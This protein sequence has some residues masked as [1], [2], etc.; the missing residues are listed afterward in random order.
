MAVAVPVAE[1]FGLPAFSQM[2]SVVR[3]Y[4]SWA[5]QVETVTFGTKL[6]DRLA[7]ELVMLPIDGVLAVAAIA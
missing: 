3:L 6:Q 5:L 2:L 7:D 4:W 1:V